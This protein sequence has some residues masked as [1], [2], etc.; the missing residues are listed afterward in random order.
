MISAVVLGLLSLASADIDGASLSDSRYSECLSLVSK[1]P[2]RAVEL[3]RAWQAG[4]GNIGARQCMG[5]AYIALQRPAPA[6]LSFE[7]AARAAEAVR[8]LRAT[9][10]WAQAGNAYLIAGDASKAR[11][12]IDTAIARGEGSDAWRGELHIDRARAD[13]ELGD[14]SA[15]RAS[16]NQAL[17]LVPA[18]P[19]GWLLSATLAR[20]QNDLT[21]AAADILEAEQRAGDDP[22]ILLEAGN[23]ALLSGSL[24]KAHE[25]WA[26]VVEVAPESALAKAA[27][28]ARD[29]N[30]LDEIE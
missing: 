27:Q 17:E 10:L 4:G 3:A 8:D 21:R 15:A 1:E 5:M 7:Q 14:L 22:H 29:E 30:P 24:T 28:K 25:K 11:A 23:I 20:R 18:D 26:R 2:E 6:A 9:D 16:L 13:V 12:A 19:M